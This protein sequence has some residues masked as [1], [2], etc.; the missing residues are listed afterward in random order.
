MA[1]RIRFALKLTITLALLGY[2][3]Y[4]KVDLQEF[5]GIVGSAILPLILLAAVVQAVTVPI[6]AGRWMIILKSFGIR[7]GFLELVRIAYIGF[8][9]NFFLPTGVGGDLFRAYYLAKRESCGMSRALVSIA[10]ERS[11]GMGALLFLGL[12]ASAV[13]QYEF[14]GILLLHVFLVITAIY[15]LANLAV[16]HPRLHRL[17]MK[18]LRRL[19]RDELAEK[20][21][22][23]SQGMRS[24]RGSPRA[25]MQSMGISLI[26]Q[27]LAIMVV[28]LSALAIRLDIPFGVFLIFVPIVNIS[29]MLPIS[30][31]GVG[32]RENLYELLFQPLGVA[33]SMSV[34]ISL[35]SYLAF[36]IAGLPGG[37]VY[38]MYKRAEPMDDV[39][40]EGKR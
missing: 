38:S 20:V 19:K 28:W 22:L 37:I 27:V 15:V 11:A 3:F 32:I 24:L 23:V 1:Q 21:E 29:I 13:T 33:A 26:V 2:V 34:S 40:A 6:A 10:L 12:G 7:P 9:F 5:L 4:F 36:L 17:M 8:F 18:I 39:L 14:Q 31:N 35:L 16:F 25:L 30:I